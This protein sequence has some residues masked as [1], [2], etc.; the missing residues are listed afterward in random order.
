MLMRRKKWEPEGTSGD[1]G[2]KGAKKQVSY[3]SITDASGQLKAVTVF[4]ASYFTL[5]KVGIRLF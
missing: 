2:C 1:P 4:I 5:A 3:Q